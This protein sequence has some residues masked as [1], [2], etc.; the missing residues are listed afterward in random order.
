MALVIL[1]A[2]FVAA[3]Q[4]RVQ[5]LA[6]VRDIASDQRAQRLHVSL[7]QELCAGT[8]SDGV[9]IDDVLVYTGEHLGE[10]YRIEARITEMDNPVVGRVGYA[11]RPRVA[12]R[13]Y[14]VEIAG[15]RVEFLWDG[16]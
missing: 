16:R 9:I 10:A 7:F 6:G 15:E 8:I 3:L 11:V 12:I 13:V 4:V 14:M 2:A 5:L 1:G